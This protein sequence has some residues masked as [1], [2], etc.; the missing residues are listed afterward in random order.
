MKLNFLDSGL[1]S[2]KKGFKSLVEYEKVTFYN[3]EEVSEEKRFYHLKDAILFIQHGIEILVKKIIQNHSEYLIFSQIDN[4]VKSALKQKNERNLNSVFETDLKHKIHTVSFN[5]SIE[6]LKIIPGVKLSSTLEKRLNELESYRNIIMHSEPYLNEYDINITFDGLSDELD[7]FFYE[8]IGETYKMISGYD[9]LMK[10]IET[11][12]ELLQE[13]GLDLKIKSVE[14]IVKALKKAKI[15][16]GS[17]EVKRITNINSCSKFLEE[18]INS[19]LTFGT[20]LYN[21]FCSGAIKKFKR[22]GENLFEFYAAENQTSY[23]YKIKS[24]IIYIP[25]IN[26]DK[27]PIIFVE[28]D[29][30]EFDSKDYD[31]QELDVFDEIKSFRYLKSIKDNEF[32]Y[33]KEKIYSI[34]ESSIIQNG[35]YED[36]YKFFT[37]GIFCFLNIQGLDYNQGFKRFIW[38]QK[39]MDGKQ[40]E[41]VLREVL[42]K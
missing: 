8:N 41:V 4:H 25:P 39:T 17:N 18:M 6:R 19:D 7:A 30:M 21:G 31:G 38:Q 36:Y 11:F 27:S 26:N 14:I 9:E 23:Q 1:D 20:D 42:T 2:L 37:K 13:K 32:V 12:K 35:N 34:L 24:I 3:K 22:G 10:N 29:N 5:E 40:F 16:I 15:S 28:S 33:K